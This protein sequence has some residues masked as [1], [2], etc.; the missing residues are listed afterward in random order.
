MRPYPRPT[1]RQLDELTAERDE[2][3][4][5]VERL[6]RDTEVRG[7]ASTR[8][9]GCLMAEVERLRDRL[10]GL[11]ALLRLRLDT[12]RDLDWL[13]RIDAALKGADDE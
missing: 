4:A 1:Q 9:I 5:E 6:K 3:R 12:G 8:Q 2:A 7:E 10:R 13:R 11:L